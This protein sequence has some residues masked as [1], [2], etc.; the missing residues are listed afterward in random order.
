M[1]K[2][3]FTHFQCLLGKLVRVT[4][5]TINHL[6][7]S[8]LVIC[9]GSCGPIKPTLLWWMAVLIRGMTVGRGDD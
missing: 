6:P 3:H 5:I 9:G 8:T 4:S 2:L 1:E 7:Y